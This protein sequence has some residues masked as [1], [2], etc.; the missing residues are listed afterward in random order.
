MVRVP[1]LDFRLRIAVR[2]DAPRVIAEGPLGARR[3]LHAAHGTF[4]GPSLNGSVLPGGGDWV[5]T[6]RDGAAELDI[7]FALLTTSDELIYLR[8]NGL[9][10]AA[11]AVAARIRGGEDVSPDAYYFRTAILFE[12]GAARLADLNRTLHIGVGQRTA[13]GMVTDVFALSHS[14]PVIPSAARDPGPA[15][16]PS[17]RLG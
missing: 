10:V 15:V 13:T 4:E 14:H 2:F 3:L 9:F 6:R 8:A 16:D 5:L 17:Q 11:D 7:R 1:A 12:T